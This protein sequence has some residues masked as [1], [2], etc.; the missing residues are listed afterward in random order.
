MCKLINI[1]HIC[2]IYNSYNGTPCLLRPEHKVTC[3]DDLFSLDFN[4]H[5]FTYLTRK[6]MFA[7]RE[8]I[9][10]FCIDVGLVIQGNEDDELP[11]NILF[12]GRFNHLNNTTSQPR[13]VA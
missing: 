1:Y 3:T 2:C 6:T 4:S 9:P 13:L 7:V 8:L 11:E 5:E 12:C 10:E